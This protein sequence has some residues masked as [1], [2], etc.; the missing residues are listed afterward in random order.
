MKNKLVKKTII[1][2]VI[3]I[4]L[5]SI[6]SIFLTMFISWSSD[7]S[8]LGQ[9]S[10]AFYIASLFAMIGNYGGRVYHVS[11]MTNDYSDSNYISL[12]YVSDIIMIA[13]T[14]IF[15]ISNAYAINKIALILFFVLYRAFEAISDSY[16]AVMQKK[17]N[18]EQVGKSMSF[19]AIISTILFIILYLIT[20]NILISSLSF[21]VV[22]AL[23]TFLYDKK[24]CE[25]YKVNKIEINKKTFFLL[26][27]CFPIFIFSFLTLLIA[28]ITRYFVDLRLTDIDQG[29]FGISV[30]PASLLTLFAQFLIQPLFKNLVDQYHKKDNR[31]FFLN[32]KKMLLVFFG[33]GIVLSILM[34]FVG[35]PILGF[36]YQTDLSNFNL[37]IALMIFAGIC[38]GGVTIIY[39]AMTIMRKINIQIVLFSISAII[40]I[41]L[42][43]FM[44]NNLKSAIFSYIIIMVCQFIIFFIYYI[45]ICY[46]DDMYKRR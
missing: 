16:Y 44:I 8:S 33:F 34:Y 12:K 28:N 35:A 37:K 24:I 3:G 39:S 2:N 30:L 26:K 6:Y 46:I 9:F 23:F 20:K 5:N 38:T 15:C 1:W 40:S 29:Y 42:S 4:T 41:L 43:I 10:Y 36:V 32:I 11:D 18:L 27:K 21:V 14:L 13:I 22:Y 31:E 25:K 45:Y 19:K 17:D 7:M